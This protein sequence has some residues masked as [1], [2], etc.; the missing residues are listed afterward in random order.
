MADVAV[1]VANLWWRFAEPYTPCAL[2]CSERIDAT[3]A[4]ARIQLKS[5]FRSS[6]RV[7]DYD[8]E[9]AAVAGPR[10]PAKPCPLE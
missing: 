7:G 6:Q 3:N 8:V 2:P 4:G 9:V 1:R 5:D 10:S